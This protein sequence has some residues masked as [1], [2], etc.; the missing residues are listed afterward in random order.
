MKSDIKGT[1]LVEIPFL[2][3]EITKSNKRVLIIGERIGNEGIIETVYAKTK[4][5]LCTDI[6]EMQTPS[7]LS[8]IIKECPTVDFIQGDFLKFNEIE[9]FDYIVCINVLEHFGMNFCNKPM[10]SGSEILDDDIIHWNYDLKAISKMIKLLQ[11]D[12][13][14]II[15]VP[16][17]PPILNGDC[18]PETTL[19]FL[20]RYDDVR[21][22]IIKKLVNISGCILNDTFFYSQDFNDW[23]SAEIE[24]SSAQNFHLQCPYSPNV[25]WAFTITKNKI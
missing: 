14:I 1:K 4:T 7:I 18:D 5:I 8:D 21:I 15:T 6:M 25:I 11:S 12:G 3:Q 2:D 20:R 19:P 10:F 9:K 23:L 17:G 22:N 13:K 16:C 24:V